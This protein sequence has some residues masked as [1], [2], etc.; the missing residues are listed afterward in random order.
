RRRYRADPYRRRL[1]R[2]A[3]R[4][5]HTRL[6]RATVTVST[7]R[8]RSVPCGPRLAAVGGATA[9]LSPTPAAPAPTI[10]AAVISSTSKVIAGPLPPPPRARHG[11]CWR[12]F[13][14]HEH[15]D[16]LCKKAVSLCVRGEML[17]ITL[18]ACARA[19]AVTWEN[20]ILILCIKGRLRLST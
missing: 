9:M 10:A 18:T 6:T 14:V 7:A 5:A 4:G 2:Q 16:D 12:T 1:H 11:S 17:G 15:V 8:L 20:T 19:S 13:S 3:A